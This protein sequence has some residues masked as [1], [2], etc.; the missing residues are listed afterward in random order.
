MIQNKEKN[1]VDFEMN[2]AA[3][4]IWSLHFGFVAFMA[5]AP[6]LGNRYA[7]VL[8]AV[9]TPF[10]WLHWILNDDTCVLTLLE[11]HLR[12]LEH[13]DHSFFYNL[14]S[15]V[16]KVKD[17]DVRTACWVASVLLWLVTLTKVGWADILDVLGLT[18]L[19]SGL[20][21]GLSSTRIR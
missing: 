3:A 8:H 17:G 18:G 7:L 16:Y 21:F 11:K 13:D 12:G 1:T 9:I 6:F 4:L 15:P 20:S 19:G 14:V 10:L 2:L 5:L